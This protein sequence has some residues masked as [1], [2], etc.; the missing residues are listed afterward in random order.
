M[1]QLAGDADVQAGEE[2]ISITLKCPIT[3]TKIKYPAR[4]EECKHFQCFDMFTWLSANEKKPTMKCPI[5]SKKLCF[6]KMRPEKYFSEMLTVCGDNVAKVKL[7]PS[8]SW[9]AYDDYD[10]KVVESNADGSVDGLNKVAVE[11]QWVNNGF[12]C[13]RLQ[14]PER[15][16]DRAER[17]WRECEP[18]ATGR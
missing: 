7:M 16:Q 9:A 3:L 14:S 1:S 2:T 10:V 15:R 4:G 18:E 6:S 17:H 13:T 11:A 8:G 5:C 12:N